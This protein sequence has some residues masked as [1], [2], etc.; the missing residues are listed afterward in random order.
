MGL[1]RAVKARILL[2]DA[3]GTSIENCWNIRYKREAGGLVAIDLGD[4]FGVYKDYPPT[5]SA[6][7]EEEFIDMIVTQD[8]VRGFLWRGASVETEVLAD[9]VKLLPFD[10]IV[11]R[12]GQQLKY[13][14]SWSESMEEEDAPELVIDRI[15]LGV[16]AI[17]VKDEPEIGMLVPTWYIKYIDKRDAG[18]ILPDEWIAF[19]AIDGSYIEPRMSSEV[20]ERYS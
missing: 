11:M 13:M 17:N 6:P 15:V 12:A 16:S 5:H 20:F 10:E 9:N 18:E 14:Y 2:S 4:G 19:N 3:S 8:G 7:W 1:V